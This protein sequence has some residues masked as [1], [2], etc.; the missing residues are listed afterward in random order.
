MTRKSEVNTRYR[1]EG[2]SLEIVNL[3]DLT[4]G[5]PLPDFQNAQQWITRVP[6]S[7]VTAKRDYDRSQFALYVDR[8]FLDY[9][10][11]SLS[12]SSKTLSA[13]RSLRNSSLSFVSTFI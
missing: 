12:R 6:R 3:Q 5:E 9:D 11:A 1:S 2:E 7:I 10:N 4:G 8:L 13:Y